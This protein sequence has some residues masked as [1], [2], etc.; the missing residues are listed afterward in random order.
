MVVLVTAGSVLLVVAV[1]L[2]TAFFHLNPIK[3]GFHR[4][5]FGRYVVLTRSSVLGSEFAEMSQVMSQNEVAIG[6][7]YKSKVQLILC[8]RQSDIGRYQPFASG[9]D[10]R[11]AGA[12]APWPNTVYITP[13]VLQ[14]PG[15]IKN[16]LGH[17]LSHVLL[18]Q[19]YGITT[20]TLLWKKAEWIPEGFATYLNSWPFYFPRNQLLARMKDSGID[21]NIQ[22]FPAPQQFAKLS[23]PVRFMAYRYFVEYL[24]Q[25]QPSAKVVLFLKDACTN[26]WNTS[27]S[28]EK[29]FGDSLDEYWIAF[30]MGLIEK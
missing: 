10:K 4:F 18:I 3:L 8:E 17:E 25:R 7:Q 21:L 13:K 11:N 22:R 1:L 15:T 14:E 27:A 2:Q 29:A 5:D 30:R 12:F 23:L 24:Y 19:N 16:T 26:P 20:S 9:A 6:L 28:F